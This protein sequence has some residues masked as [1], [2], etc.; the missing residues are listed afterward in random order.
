MS[1]LS[2]PTVEPSFWVDHLDASTSRFSGELDLATADHAL[3][4]VRGAL[5]RAK[6]RQFTLDVQEVSF[7]DCAG[8]EVLIA[9]QTEAEQSGI[10]L[11]VVGQSPMLLRVLSVLGMSQRFVAAVPVKLD[12]LV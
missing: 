10:V 7:I 6:V 11:R 8:I 5:K 1:A 4:S 2:Q 9:L 3:R 12:A